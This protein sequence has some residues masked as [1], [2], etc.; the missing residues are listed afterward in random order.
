LDYN[1]FFSAVAQS[2]AAIVGIF[3]AFIISKYINFEKE[4][5]EFSYQWKK[6]IIECKAIRDE[7]SLIHFNPIKT[8]DLHI[9][10]GQAKKLLS[11]DKSISVYK[12]ISS[13]YKRFKYLPFS[14]M[15][16]VFEEI[17]KTFE[18]I[19]YQH[20]DLKKDKESADY[21][22][23]FSSMKKQLPVVSS[24]VRKVNLEIQN[25]KT[26]YS[27]KYILIFS[28]I[29]ILIIFIF[30][31]LFPLFLLP[32]DTE[33]NKG[34]NIPVFNNLN[35]LNFDFIPSFI[36]SITSLFFGLGLFFLFIMVISK[37]YVFK[38]EKIILDEFKEAKKFHEGMG[39]NQELY[40]EIKTTLD[41]KDPK[42]NTARK[43]IYE[44]S[45]YQE[46]KNLWD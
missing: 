4:I 38:R 42:N 22:L 36:L 2:F 16:Y 7:L 30:G 37:V 9:F 26:L 41:S 8:L 10:Q 12:V 31:V 32:Y 45:Y 39:N 43:D 14:E 18:N 6:L 17:L 21:E 24:L 20:K 15:K 28:I 3:G 40:L 11:G 1:W 35:L 27:T 44:S 23:K 25:F 13:E 34:N 33:S 19:D 46:L 5:N 29:F